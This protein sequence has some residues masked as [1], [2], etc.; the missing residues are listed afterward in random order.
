MLSFLNSAELKR[1]DARG[2]EVVGRAIHSLILERYIAKFLTLSVHPTPF[3]NLKCLMYISGFH[4][5]ETS[6][7]KRGKTDIPWKLKSAKR[8]RA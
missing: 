4:S 3:I 2:A 8:L 5:H 1:L 7:S 6:R